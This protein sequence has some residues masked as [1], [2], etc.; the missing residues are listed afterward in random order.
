M[1]YYLCTHTL[2]NYFSLVP[3]FKSFTKVKHG[4]TSLQCSPLEIE[5]RR[6]RVQDQSWQHRKS[7]GRMDQMRSALSHHKSVLHIVLCLIP[8][9]NLAFSSLSASLAL[10]LSPSFLSSSPHPVHFYANTIQ[11][12]IHFPG[13]FLL[14]PRELLCLKRY[15]VLCFHHIT[16]HGTFPSRFLKH[17]C[18]NAGEQ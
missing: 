1:S 14:D 4:D 7:E 6:S 9:P 5:V 10:A 12:N 15:S 18:S 2:C 16:Y 17:V 8:T 13:C 11:E 3:K